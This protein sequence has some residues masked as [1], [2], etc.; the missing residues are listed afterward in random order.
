MKSILIFKVWHAKRLTLFGDDVVFAT[1][2][3]YMDPITLVG[4]LFLKRI[5]LGRVFKV[6]F[7]KIS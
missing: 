7:M 4:G 2:F 1:S 6:Y 5:V 3:L